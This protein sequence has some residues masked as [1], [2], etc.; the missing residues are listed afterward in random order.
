MQCMLTLIVFGIR[1]LLSS[2]GGMN[3]LRVWGGG[4]YETEAFYKAADEL[5]LMVLQDGQ[6]IRLAVLCRLFFS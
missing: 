3:T 2:E 1:I 5:G 6:C 4:I